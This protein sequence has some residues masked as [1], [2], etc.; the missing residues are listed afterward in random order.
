[1]LKYEQQH[2]NRIRASQ[3]KDFIED[4]FVEE[5]IELNIDET[6]LAATIHNLAEVTSTKY[7]HDTVKFSYRTNKENSEKIK[8]LSNSRI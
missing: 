7:N 2:E 5:E 1:M 3:S 8:K 6:K 4:S